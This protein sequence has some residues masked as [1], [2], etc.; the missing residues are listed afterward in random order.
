MEG[1]TLM[2]RHALHI[3]MGGGSSIGDCYP[4]T[5]REGSQ[6]ESELLRD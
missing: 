1:K 2:Y 4:S 3:G 5:A 6:F